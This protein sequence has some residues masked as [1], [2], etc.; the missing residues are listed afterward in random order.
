M[1]AWRKRL[2]VT[3]PYHATDTANT[4]NY[5]GGTAVHH[6]DGKPQWICNG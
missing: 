4:Y 2:A 3:S 5:N 1:L 6:V